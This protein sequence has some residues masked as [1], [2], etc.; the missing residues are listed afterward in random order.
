MGRGFAFAIAL[1]GALL[2]AFLISNW[3]SPGN[4]FGDPNAGGASIGVQAVDKIPIPHEG[5]ENPVAHDTESEA[6]QAPPK[7]VA[8]EKEVIPPDAIKLNLRQ[9]K[10]KQ[11][12]EAST[13][14]HFKS[15]EQLEKNQLY[16]KS[17]QAVSSPLYSQTPGSGRVGL[18]ANTTLG[19][20][21]AGYAQQIQELISRNWNTGDVTARTAPP[22]IATFELMRDGSV[23]HLAILQGSGVPSLDFSVRRAIEGVTFPPLPPTYEGSS[24]K[25]EFTFE[26][27]K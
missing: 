8:Q 18:G 23:R 19:S 17:P 12:K 27:K 9:D 10:K 26:L 15:F 25:C 16:S 11:A 24:A 20:R 7:P 3:V 21:F 1:H 22:V 5:R 4:T 2:A 14:H 13:P 6:P